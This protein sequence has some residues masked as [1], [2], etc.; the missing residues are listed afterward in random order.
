MIL[1]LILPPIM[2]L[3]INFWGFSRVHAWLWRNI[4]LAT[5]LPSLPDEFEIINLCHL[6]NAAANRSPIHTNCLQ[7]SL[8][9]WWLLRRIGVA[10][11]LR[12][13]VDTEDGVFK[14]HAWLEKN[15]VVLNDSPNSVQ[16]FTP[17]DQAI[18]PIMF[19]TL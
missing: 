3:A 1:A 7:R 12:I 18:E 2:R 6:V 15:G 5:A 17:F 8:T 4:P 19:D 11:D 14:A 13:G 16:H 10:S 9:L